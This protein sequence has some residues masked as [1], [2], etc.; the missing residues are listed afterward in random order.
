MRLHTLLFVA[1]LVLLPAVAHGQVEENIQSSGVPL[2]DAFSG[3]PLKQQ[4]GLKTETS[5]LRTELNAMKW[6]DGSIAYTQ[7]MNCLHGYAE[8]NTGA[9]AGYYGDDQAT[10]PRVGD[11]YYTH[12]VIYGLGNPC[13]GN[14]VVTELALPANTYLAISAQNPVLCYYQ[15]TQGI[16]S[17]NTT[18]CPQTATQ[19]T[20]GYRFT[21]TNNNNY[22]WPL[23]QGAAWEIRVPVYSTA[24]MSGISTNSYIKW[25]M[26]S[27]DGVYNQW[28]HPQI[29]VFVASNTPSITY[30]TPSSTSITDTTVRN[31]ANVFN[32][33]TAGNVYFD[34]GTTTAYGTTS[35]PV[36]V[37]DTWSSGAY[38]M[39]WGSL[40]P[41][42]TY[43]W[44]ARFVSSAGATTTGANQTFTTTGTAPVVRVRGDFNADGRA[45]LLW[46]NGGAAQTALWQMNGL[47]V[48]TS[49][50]LPAAAPEWAVAGVA[51]FNLNSYSDILWRNT[52][53]GEVVIW[54]MNGAAIDTS[55]SVATP[56]PAW[57]IEGVG[58]FN[59][60]TIADILLRN[61]N[62][63]EAVVWLMNG[64][65]GI[66]SAASVASPSSQWSVQGVGDF[67][68]DGRTDI[69]WRNSS[70]SEAWVWL[71]NG[72]AIGST[73]YVAS[74]SSAWSVKGVGDFSGDGKADIAWRNS[75][76]NEVAVW[77][78]NGTS[79]AG[80]GYVATPPPVWD[81]RAVGDFDGN[82]RADMMWRNT[83]SG[84]N[85]IWL[86][87]GLTIGSTGYIPTLADQNW[88]VVGPR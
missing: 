79:I 39:D 62:T 24:T 22:P 50:Y 85:V 88:T 40:T 3:A 59:G 58:D 83:S 64:A 47:T 67:N 73:G 10:F 36:A 48:S 14:Y 18:N 31:N 41:G 20:Y 76:T 75:S 81:L 42:T 77:T 45:D 17:Q 23:A 9:Y 78:M 29:G 46:R 51:H 55:G 80:A 53:T 30:P 27:I 8:N 86:M 43:H 15:N 84:E 65:F 54:M 32:N 6:I 16:W 49:A 70:T 82:A 1:V 4:S 19:G 21:P 13:S 33:Y 61:S 68:G 63:S 28:A 66:A 12:G 87:N 74:P 5:G 34:I 56:P 72:A 57:N 7:T 25:P 44:R 37:P 11:V 71:M 69:L 60:D 26:Q 35:S 52:S 2:P 38:Y